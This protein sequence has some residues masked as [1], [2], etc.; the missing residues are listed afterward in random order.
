MINAINIIKE[1][2]CKSTEKLENYGEMEYSK[3]NLH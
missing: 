2:L 1:K 3:S